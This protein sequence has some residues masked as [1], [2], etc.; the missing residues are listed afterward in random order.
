MFQ[1]FKM[2]FWYRWYCKDA[3]CTHDH[4]ILLTFDDGPDPEVTPWVLN[5]LAPYELSAVFFCIGN[6]IDQ[7]RQVLKEIV[8]AGHQL[9]NHTQNHEN[10]WK[11]DTKSYLKSINICQPKVQNNLFRPPYGKIK[12]RQLRAIQKEGFK[13]ML[14]SLISRDYDV[15][16]SPEYALQQLKSKTQQNSIVVFHDSKKAFPQLQ[17]ILP[18]YLAYLEKQG[19][20]RKKSH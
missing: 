15:N 20:I 18:P 1:W 8:A 2:P 10:A 14:W 16:T 19:L 11:T 4:G 3:I 13:V 12:R 9:G 5:Q 7:H 17:H 6:Q